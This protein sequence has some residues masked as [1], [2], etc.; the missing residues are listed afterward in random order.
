MSTISPIVNDRQLVVPGVNE[1]AQPKNKRAGLA[2]RVSVGQ[3]FFA[4]GYNCSGSKPFT[5][6]PTN[7]FQGQEIS[8]SGL[9]I[10]GGQLRSVRD[11][12]LHVQ[13]TVTTSDASTVKLIPSEQWFKQIELHSTAGG[14][15]MQRF[16][17]DTI[18]AHNGWKEKEQY[19]MIAKLNGHT[20][21]WT[22]SDRAYASGEVIDRYIP[23]FFAF[24]EMYMNGF[25]FLALSKT[26]D[27][28]F[29]FFSRGSIL[30][31]A[32]PNATITVNALELH[33]NMLNFK[34]DAINVQPSVTITGQNMSFDFL[35]PFQVNVTA[36]TINTSTKTSITLNNLNTKTAA[37]L[38]MGIRSNSSS[39]VDNRLT[40]FLEL[41]PTSTL[42]LVDPS[43]NSIFGD[44]TAP[45]ALRYKDALSKWLPGEMARYSNMYIFNF[46]RDL[47]RSHR[48]KIGCIVFDSDS[49]RLEFTPSVA[50]TNMVQTITSSTAPAGGKYRFYFSGEFSDEL[51]YNAS[52]ANQKAALEAMHIFREWITGPITI[53]VSA[54]LSAGTSRTYTFNKCETLPLLQIVDSSLVGAAAEAVTNSTTVSTA[55]V[56]GWTNGTYEVMLYAFCP[57]TVTVVNGILKMKEY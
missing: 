19:A 2:S 34:R 48:F 20:E 3:E 40:T 17:G 16:Y 39:V 8:T 47:L 56:Q 50:A 45:P 5:P 43:G 41:P 49:Y 57:K 15:I 42:D 37:F 26:N 24:P 6:V 9:K 54:A 53:T 46:S 12:T 14:E 22:G 33:V 4:A 21:F 52:A 44:G 55:P 35:E 29:K 30:S 38:L 25:D 51:A 23:L 11:M 13:I 31:V 28:E 18:W 36:Q 1:L 10:E 27:L 32:N 7:L